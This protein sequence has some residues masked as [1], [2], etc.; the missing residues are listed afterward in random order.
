MKI[1]MTLPTMVR[2]YSRDTTLAWCRQIDTGP[3]HSLSAGE[4]VTYHNQD[5]LVTLSAAAAVTDRVRVI[6]TIVI[7][8]MHPAPVVAKEAATLDVLSGGRFT[9]GLGVGG[10]EHDYRASERSFG[11]RWTR[12]DESVSTIRRI[13]AGEPPFEGA[14]PVGPPVVQDG[15]PPLWCSSFG[16]KSLARASKWAEGYAGFTLAGDLAELQT[17]AAT[18][19]QAWQDSGRTTAPYLM[20]GGWFSLGAGA[21]ERHRAYVAEYIRIDPSMSFMPDTAGIVGDDALR[22]ALDNSEA[23]G[24][25]EF[26]LVPTTADVAEL[27]RVQ[28]VLD[29]R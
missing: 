29:Q 16:P 21:A 22:R 23:A 24:Y 5:Q 17:T 9:L 25:D 12:L 20:G 26:M 8:P 13:W 3:Y 14:D 19:K 28:A 10:R 15:G 7:L 1:G 6:A 11:E 27:E 4:R 18:V 2:G